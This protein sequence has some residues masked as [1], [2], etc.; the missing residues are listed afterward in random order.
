MPLPSKPT[1][2][3]RYTQDDV[4]KALIAIKNDGYSIS[5]ASRCF[6]VP[7]TTLHDKL[8]GKYK[9]E[10]PVGR[11]SV[12]TQKEEDHIVQWVLNVAKA[13]FPVT[14]GQ[15]IDSVAR[16]I[17]ELNRPNQFN[18]NVPGDKWYNLFLGRHPEIAQ[19]VSQALIS[20]RA[21]VTEAQVR[22]WF[23][24]VKTY[25]QGK[26]L[27]D[28]FN[29]P[30]RIFNADETAFFLCPKG[31]KVLARK[32]EKAVYQ[33]TGNDEKECLTVLV[34]ANAAGV[35]APP[36]VVFRYE[37][38]PPAIVRTFPEEWGL[39]KS[40]NG[41]MTRETFF[42]YITN[43]F[44][45]WLAAQK[46]PFPILLFIDG[47]TSHMS[48]HLS[49]YCSKNNIE[50]VALYPNS[51]HL[52]QPLDVAVF[53]PL[54][55][56]WKRFVTE[57]RF[58]NDGRRMKR[59]EFSPLLKQVL[60]KL[61]G[62]VVASGFRATGLDTLDPD[63]VHYNLISKRSTGTPLT[64]LA[65]E[66]KAAEVRSHLAYIEVKMGLDKVQRFNQKDVTL[67]EEALFDVW[68]SVKRDLLEIDERILEKKRLENT[69]AST[70]VRN[71]ATA[72]ASP[73]QTTSNIEHAPSTSAEEEVD[74]VLALPLDTE[75]VAFLEGRVIAEGSGDAVDESGLQN[76]IDD[77]GFTDAD[78]GISIE[79][80]TT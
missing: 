10:V 41:W 9:E 5:A 22:S 58:A 57:W 18:N 7:K 72:T 79:V 2:R 28:V 11:P 32:G 65:L 3:Q 8:H 50:V 71:D 75:G 62:K 4:Q 33:Q 21:N 19:R 70:P 20:S 67:R 64:T 78:Q 31:K 25:L 14:K 69:A 43:V 80:C 16:L 23:S 77:L 49:D 73:H 26:N 59:E 27:L 63:K 42:E 51:T 37:R 46:I 56:E 24:E 40:E 48:I 6:N 12:L 1:S 68:S 66:R 54:K 13:G 76:I 15:L 39:A 53:R 34:N 17:S 38:V 36:M 47:H 60:D 35:M 30:R 44:H 74:D 55:M 61:D 29:D 52:L 45:P